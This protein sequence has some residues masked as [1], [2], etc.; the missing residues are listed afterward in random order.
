VQHIPYR[1]FNCPHCGAPGCVSYGNASYTCTCRFRTFVS[2][3]PQPRYSC[4]VAG[5]PATHVSKYDVCSTVETKEVLQVRGNGPGKSDLETTPA[6]EAS[7]VKAFQ[8]SP[9][10]VVPK[11]HFWRGEKDST[12]CNNCGCSY[13]SHTITDE[14][15]LCP[16]E[17]R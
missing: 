9:R 10:R 6:P 4:M 11:G 5:C 1:E 16:T 15:T 17:N 3:E 14:A 8:Q 7:L 2:A 13:F 12:H